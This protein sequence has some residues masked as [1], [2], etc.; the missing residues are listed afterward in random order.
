[1][2][3]SRLLGCQSQQGAC[4]HRVAAPL[5]A[6][7]S[8]PG[9]LEGAKRSHPHPRAYRVS[10]NCL[11]TGM[12]IRG[13]V[14]WEY[15][16][17]SSLLFSAGSC[18]RGDGGVRTR[19]DRSRAARAA[20]DSIV[21]VERSRARRRWARSG[22]P[23][24]LPSQGSRRR[25]R[26]CRTPNVCV[27]QR[28]P[29]TIEVTSRRNWP[30]PL[31]K[32]A[33][34]HVSLASRAKTLAEP[35]FRSAIHTDPIENRG[36]DEQAVDV[37]RG[38]RARRLQVFSMHR[39]HVVVPSSSNPARGVHRRFTARQ[40]RVSAAREWFVYATTSVRGGAA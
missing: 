26:T 33:K 8:D 29:Y 22:A 6:T 32:V 20:F 23:G 4:S 5:H 14:W 2:I 38:R 27:T 7:A 13:A 11:V 31:Q 16:R 3:I 9:S 36:H 1:M 15:R 21:A 28:V 30:S 37:S 24:R 40:G 12:S 18:E 39:V 25:S 10:A 34:K 17:S 19:A 35:G